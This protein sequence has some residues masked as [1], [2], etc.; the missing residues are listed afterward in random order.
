LFLALKL[1]DGCAKRSGGGG[2]DDPAY[3]RRAGGDR[4]AFQV[5][6]K[7]TRRDAAGMFAFPFGKPQPPD[8]TRPSTSCKT[9][10]A[11]QMRQS[12]ISPGT[13]RNRCS[14]TTPTSARRRSAGP[15][16]RPRR[17]QRSMRL[18]GQLQM[19]LGR[20]RS[21]DAV[22]DPRERAVKIRYQTEPSDCRSRRERRRRA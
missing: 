18:S 13:S 12:G 1:H 5:V 16:I 7:E 2:K 15:W 3:R 8:P 11:I 22:A 6:P 19:R 4:G 20:S 10:W 14:S 9:V 17:S 21:H